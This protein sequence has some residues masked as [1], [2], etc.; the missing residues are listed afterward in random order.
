MAIL[1]LCS[2]VIVCN[3]AFPPL[4]PISAKYFESV[5]FSMHKIYHLGGLGG[6]ALDKAVFIDI[7]SGLDENNLGD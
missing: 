7:L 5:D 3:L 4:R 6:N 1:C 2:A